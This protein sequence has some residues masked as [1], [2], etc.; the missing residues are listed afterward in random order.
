MILHDLK[1][2]ADE[3]GTHPSFVHWSDENF[4]TISF[5]EC[6]ELSDRLSAAVKVTAKIGSRV[7]LIVLKHHI[8]QLP[9]F[10][11]CMKAGLIPSFLPFPSTKQDPDL[12]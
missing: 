3:R 9:L 12:F 1:R 10:L 8:L 6:D 2:H 11:G 5:A 4:L 7:V